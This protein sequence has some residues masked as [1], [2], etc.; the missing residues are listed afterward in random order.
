MFTSP[1]LGI[2]CDHRESIDGTGYREDHLEVKE[3][4]VCHSNIHREGAA[5]TKSV[6]WRVQLLD[7]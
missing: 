3:F 6:I 1:C 2:D 7:P 5:S 4:V